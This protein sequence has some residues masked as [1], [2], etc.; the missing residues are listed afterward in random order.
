MIV[1]RPKSSKL[2]TLLFSFCF[3]TVALATVTF[4]DLL[5]ES[6]LDFSNPASLKE[7]KPQLN[8]VLSYERAHQLSGGNLE[9]RYAIRPISRV[10]I[11]YEDPHNAAPDPNH[12]F[13]LLF[14]TLVADL[15]A[16]RNSPTQ[17]YSLEQ[18]QAQFNADWAAAATFD[19]VDD[20]SLQYQQALMIA[21]HKN[22]KADA[23]I[24]FLFDDYPSV[25]SE[26]KQNM[27]NLR[28][29]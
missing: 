25:K 16:N 21:M 11:D 9:I 1:V 19:V 8:Q 12:L 10:Q 13:P 14:Q 26:I 15:A 23:Y 28:F 6:A 3:C 27:G 22:H 7:V 18:A 20:F 24:I 29:K 17:E 4:E 2:V 5:D